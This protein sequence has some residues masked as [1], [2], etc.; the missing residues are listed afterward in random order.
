MIKMRKM[1]VLDAPFVE[2]DK[3]CTKCTLHYSATPSKDIIGSSNVCHLIANPIQ[4]THIEDIISEEDGVLYSTR[5][6]AQAWDAPD[7][8]VC[9]QY[10][11]GIENYRTCFV[12][13]EDAWFT[14][15]G[16]RC[17]YAYGSVFVW[18]D[19]LCV[20]LPAASEMPNKF[21]KRLATRIL[22]RDFS[23]RRSPS[24]KLVGT[25]AKA[26]CEAIAS[27]SYVCFDVETEGYRYQTSESTFRAVCVAVDCIIDGE[28]QSFIVHKPKAVLSV[29]GAI[30]DYG[31]AGGHLIAHNASFDVS[32]LREFFEF[33]HIP[34]LHDTMVIIKLLNNDIS[35]TLQSM[36]AMLG[37]VQHKD[38]VEE[39]IQSII[40][41]LRSVNYE[42]LDPE[43][44]KNPK[45][46]L[47]GWVPKDILLPY[48]S[49]DSYRTLL[50]FQKMMK[51]VETR[52]LSALYRDLIQPATSLIEQI[53]N[54][55]ILTRGREFWGKASEAALLDAAD[56]K[57]TILEEYGVNPESPRQLYNTLQ[58]M[59]FDYELEGTSRSELQQIQHPIAQGVL[60][61]RYV[62]K[63]SN[64]LRE[65]SERCTVDGYIY[66]TFWLSVA[67]TGR[68]SC[69]H[70]NMQNIPKPDEDDGYGTLIRSGFVAPK[71]Y[72]IVDFDYEQVE[73]RVMAYLSNDEVAMR[74]VEA[75]SYHMFTARALA[76]ILW[77]IKPSEVTEEEHKKKAKTANFAWLYGASDATQAARFGCSVAVARAARK[78]VFGK[79]KGVDK[80]NKEVVEETKRL[81]YTYTNFHGQRGRIRN[82]YGIL[83]TDR[84]ERSKAERIARNTRIQGTASDICLYAGIKMQELIRTGSFG[85]KARVCWLIH[86]N[87]GCLIHESKLNQF[88]PLAGEILLGASGG[89]IPLKYS[90]EVG[91]SWD[92]MEKYE[93]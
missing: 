81:G 10:L 62:K 85:K 7:I 91:H 80:W 73:L 78:A 23:K 21:F 49:A 13:G 83:S 14:V 17:Q 48:C 58:A 69:S 19:T 51:Q 41:S 86:D 84:Y 53:N 92:K 87:I 31:V 72:V 71:G 89:S 38:E 55:G 36:C 24:P 12:W 75:G 82:V 34:H 16:N 25:K 1:K 30:T 74:E 26:A 3:Q 79:F 60:D 46:F 67:R 45:A 56:K 4:L 29:L 54:K 68:L 47:Y 18:K 8:R 6:R 37:Y 33:D 28:I 65:L 44:K 76:P 5:C 70:P 11:G 50:G 39:T 27:A 57:T 40:A 9:R 2:Y 20:F 59:N 88:L 77:G 93:K 42:G 64:Y 15:F 32:C 63:M 90:T 35:G 61:F 43:I 66:P 52:K 22:A